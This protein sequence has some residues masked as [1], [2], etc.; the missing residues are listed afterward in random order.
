MLGE[1][2]VRTKNFIDLGT[3]EKIVLYPI[4]VLIILIGIYPAPLLKISEAAVDNLWN[5]LSNYQAINK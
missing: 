3:N 4:V 5:V 2:N 1:S